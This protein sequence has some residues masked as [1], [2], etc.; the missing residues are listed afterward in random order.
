MK[1]SGF[2]VELRSDCMCLCCAWM[3]GVWHVPC[4]SIAKDGCRLN[5][6]AVRIHMPLF[7]SI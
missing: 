3:G 1:E 5:A 6:L 4:V 7:L 2:G